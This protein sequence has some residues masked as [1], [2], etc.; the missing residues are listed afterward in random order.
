MQVLCPKC[1]GR[2]GGPDLNVGTDVAHC[3]RCDEVHR[4][5]EL[6]GVAEDGSPAVDLARPP[7]GAWFVPTFDGFEAG[8]TTRSAAA[9]FIVPFMCVWSGFS[10][11]GIYGRQILRGDFELLPSLFGIPFVIGTLIF[12]SLALMTVA[13][14]VTV[15]VGGGE[16]RI[17]TGVGPFGFSRRFDWNQVQAVR[18]EHAPPGNSGR[19]TRQIAVVGATPAPLTFGSQLRDDRRAVVADA[20]R[21]PL[22]DRG[23]APRRYTMRP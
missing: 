2:I 15:R 13:G 18:Q 16:G 14:K 5:S 6:V 21:Q 12:G 17:F 10:I 11:G 1:D 19:G 4:L 3:R 23:R 7:R 9:L 22:R 20:L 8:A